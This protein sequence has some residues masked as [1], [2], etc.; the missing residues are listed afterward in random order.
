[1]AV[2]QM[3]W[4]SDLNSLTVMDYDCFFWNFTLCCHSI[5]ELVSWWLFC[6]FVKS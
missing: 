4:I 3:G 6:V 5:P 1:M 2:A